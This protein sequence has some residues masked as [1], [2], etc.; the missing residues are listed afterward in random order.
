MEPSQTCLNCDNTIIGEYCHNCGQP[1]T[2]SR[3]TFKETVSQFLSA[4]FSL[5]GQLLST[6]KQLI[7]NPGVAYRDFIKG[8]RKSYYKPVSFFVLITAL[9][10]IIRL[11][12]GFDPLALQAQN[13]TPLSDVDS[14]QKMA[15]VFMVKNV[16]YILLFLVVSIGF[17]LKIFFR[18]KYNFTEFASIGFYITGMYILV[19]I[20]FML[21]SNYFALDSSKFQ[22]LFLGVL[23]YYNTYS[24]FNRMSFGLSLKYLLVSIGS[25]FLYTMLGFG[26]SFLVVSLK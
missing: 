4:S 18:K 3:I 9:Y 11:I 23:I 6:V 13:S 7:I 22:L 19:G 8:K 17:M 2:T 20:L 25:V 21:A 24:L 10:I 15:A 1:A 16:N 14:P 12:I 26:F 5:E